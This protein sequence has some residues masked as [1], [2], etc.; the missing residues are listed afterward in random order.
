MTAVR[1]EWFQICATPVGTAPDAGSVD[2]LAD[3][4]VALAGAKSI[5]RDFQ[6]KRP[7]HLIY[8]RRV[9]TETVT[10]TDVITI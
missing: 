8:V 10:T 1:R 6:R 4:F 3:G 7:V 9:V 5:A 2:V